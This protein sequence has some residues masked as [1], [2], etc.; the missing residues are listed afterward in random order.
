MDEMHHSLTFGKTIEEARIL[1][2]LKGF[3][4][5]IHRIEHRR[6]PLTGHRSIIG[7][8]LAEKY[9][10]MSD[11]TDHNLVESIAKSSSSQCVFCPSNV[12]TATPR[13]SE[14]DLPQ[15]N[16]RVGES[17]LFPNLYPVAR[18]HAIIVISKEHF[19]RPE[20][21]S[22]ELLANA[23]RAAQLFI[24]RLPDIENSYASIICNYMPPAGASAIHPH[25]QVLVSRTPSNYAEELETALK[26]YNE[27]RG[28][29]YWDDL[30]KAEKNEDERYVGNIGEVDWIAVFSPRGADE[31][32]GVC[33]PG[34]YCDFDASLITALGEGVSRILRYYGSRNR[35]SFN[36]YMD[37]AQ[38]K[39]RHPWSR[40]TVRT[41]TRQNVYPNYRSQVHC[42]QHLLE[43]EVLVES[44]ES[45]AKGLR[46]AFDNE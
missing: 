14:I 29:C 1:S 31:F 2:P 4:E 16:I 43:T 36:F 15:G 42:F 41:V 34:S 28:A 26:R 40:V 7:L 24:S 17:F 39:T 46:N 44:P 6:D 23:F 19:L 9:K 10:T 13:F 21:F 22:P 38:L 45:I 20:D 12:L 25:L 37:L 11:N 8:S 33:A 32:L 5:T 30:I 18:H 3:N 35:S 27:C